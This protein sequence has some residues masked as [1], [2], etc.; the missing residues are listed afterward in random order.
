MSKSPTWSA[1]AVSLSFVIALFYNGPG[2]GL[3]WLSVSGTLLVIWLSLSIA[4]LDLS[5]LRFA[6]GWLPTVAI[7]YGTW[8]FLN[9][10]ISSYAYA[11]SIAAMQLALLPL[12]LLG[13][14]I[15]SSEDKARTWRF[16][17]R[18]LLLCAVALAVWGIVDLL[19]FKQRAHGPLIDANAY[20]AL[21]NLFLL[22]AAFAYLTA[23]MSARG[24]DRS[25]VLLA[26]VALLA[27]G[28]CS[29][30][31]RGAQLAFLAMAPLL[32]WFS[33]KH[34]AFRARFPWLFI[35][36]VG[37]YLLVDLV[38]VM[39]KRGIEPLLVALGHQID[40]DPAIQMRFLMWET[41]LKIIAD[42]NLITGT[43]L[44]TYKSYYAT[45]RNPQEIETS[46]NLA[47]ND[48]LQALQ[49]G[50]LI[51]LGF[52]LS[53]LMFTPAWLLYKSRSREAD[54]RSSE[55]APG[56]L[57][58]VLCISLH[59]VVNFVHFVAPIAI[60]TGLYLARSWEAVQ[61]R[62]NLL[63]LKTTRVTPGF[64]KTSAIGLL[65]IP[66]VLL[67]LDGI[68]FVFFATRDPVITQLRPTQRFMIINTALALRPANPIPRVSYI[69]DQLRYAQEFGFPAFFAEAER[70]A[71]ILAAT[72]PALASGKFFL[73]K[74]RA[75]RG[76]PDDLLLARDDLEH[77]V[78][79]VPP[80]TAMRLELVKVYRRLGR[81]ENAYQA[82]REARKWVNLEHDYRSLAA[83]AEEARVIAESRKNKEEAEYWS[84]I[85]G[86][87]SELGFTG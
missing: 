19:V 37:A 38:Q 13:W 63:V 75:M 9:P 17:W 25:N 4:K 40:M 32:L 16:T 60:L 36:L 53:L 7:A 70:Q 69:Q 83:F 50:G 74:T 84:W 31:S 5:R 62:Y 6:W 71:Q 49:E 65:A 67:V 66:T 3:H 80:A 42:A 77:A 2:H 76:T 56:L 73:G 59:A 58:G 29:A 52:F 26:I 21:I 44:G 79:L 24:I 48:Y 27:I 33:R 39:P 20:A 81:E 18:L 8:L 43:G 30:Q 82:I 55:P 41:T 57:L 45:Y 23:P 86:R 68:I 64:L 14:L 85:Y 54:L 46:G 51:Q 10:T 34:V 28:Q 35:V 22:P 12:C 72:A 61:S 47:H 11:S 78:K 1:I 15:L 87:L